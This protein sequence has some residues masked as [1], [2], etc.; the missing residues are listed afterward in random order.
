MTVNPLN[1]R[2]AY[3]PDDVLRLDVERDP[4]TGELVNLIP[5]PD[6][7]FGGWGWLTPRTNALMIAEADG[8]AYVTSNSG[9]STVQAFISEGMEV[10][11]GQYVAATWDTAGAFLSGGSAATVYGRARFEFYDADGAA[12]TPSAQGAVFS[13]AAATGLYYAPVPVPASTLTARLRFDL[14]ADAGGLSPYGTNG[15]HVRIRNVT[16]AAASTT[17]ALPSGFTAAPAYYVNLIGH[18][19]SIGTKR[20][21][22]DIGTLTAV[23]TGDDLDP[24]A[25]A[26]PVLRPG[27]RIRLMART[28]PGDPEADPVVPPTWEPLFTGSI[29]RAQVS[30]DLTRREDQGDR[31][32]VT[33]T[34]VDAVTRLAR[35]SRTGGVAHIAELPAVLEGAGVPWNVNGSGAQVTTASVVATSDN[36]SALDQL[37]IT[38]DSELGFVWV[39]RNGVLQAWDRDE[40]SDTVAAVLDEETYNASAVADYDTDRAINTVMVAQRWIDDGGA[41]QERAFGPYRDLDSIRLWGTYSATY[42]VQGFPFDF[43][44]SLATYA[45]QIL[46]AN[47]TPARRINSVVV[48]ITGDLELATLDLYDLVTVENTLADLA[49]DMRVIGVEHAITADSWLMTV[50]FADPGAAVPPQLVPR[51][52]Q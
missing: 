29:S 30:Y 25:S 1:V 2:Q 39:D 28:D 31:T 27:H 22:L 14:Y 16:A 21:E 19:G 47:A 41:T 43:G 50:R 10:T 34:A 33:I 17:G 32:R 49:G 44:A 38:R 7:E 42:T 51:L 36:A 18:T 48:P 13:F 45:A 5:N 46:A 3:L 9:P 11:P 24:A 35:E 6:G 40:I 52:T 15:T 37:I 8:L 23:L 20:G 12:L 4:E 26:T